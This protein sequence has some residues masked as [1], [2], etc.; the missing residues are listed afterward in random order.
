MSANNLE[1]FGVQS[2]PSE[3]TKMIGGEEFVL[4]FGNDGRY[5]LSKE[6]E[7]P[8]RPVPAEM[9]QITA[10]QIDRGEQDEQ[11]LVEDE[12]DTIPLEEVFHDN[13]KVRRSKRKIGKVA[14]GAAA[15]ATAWLGLS[16][17]TYWG[18][19]NFAPGEDITF[20]EIPSNIVEQATKGYDIFESIKGK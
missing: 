8:E 7:V 5:H 20:I 18:I 9:E 15:V 16:G 4:Y 3:I 6:P 13:E 10:L 14:V 1:V 17:A 12:E 19:T 11:E 2:R